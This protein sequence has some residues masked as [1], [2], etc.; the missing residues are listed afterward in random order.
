M[1]IQLKDQMDQVRERG[2]Y[3]LE[4][5]GVNYSFRQDLWS[6]LSVIMQNNPGTSSEA[7]VTPIAPRD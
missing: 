2:D 7:R 5:T 6:V 1:R 3:S 4:V